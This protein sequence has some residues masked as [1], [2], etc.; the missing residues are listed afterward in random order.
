[1]PA[2]AR[3]H[4]AVGAGRAALFTVAVAFSIG[5][6]GGCGA[7]APR[8]KTPA[9]GGV[10]G[11]SG[12]LELHESGG[13]P[14][15]VIVRREGDPQPAIAIEL[16]IP[17]GTEASG[18][19]T[20]ALTALVAA[21]LE[22][23]GVAGVQPIAGAQYAR[24]RGLVPQ[25]GAQLATA[26]DDALRIPVAPVDP[27][28]PAI[29]HALEKFSGR[30]VDDPGLARAA[31]CLDRPTRPVGFQPL[32][33]AALASTVE[34][35]RQQ[36]VRADAIVL[37]VVGGGAGLDTFLSAWS[38]LGPLVAAPGVVPQPKAAPPTNAFVGLTTQSSE[39]AV[40]VV[41]GAP[42]AAIPSTLAALVEPTSPLMLRLRG[43]DEW[44][45]KG[46]SG[47]ARAEGGCIVVEL[48]PS[49]RARLS[50]KEWNADR[51]TMRAAVALEV[52]RQEI[53]RA[54]DRARAT[55][56]GEAARLAIASGGDAREAADRAAWWGWTSTFAAGTPLRPTFTLTVP[57]PPPA[58]GATAATVDVEGF[59]GALRPKLD[60]ALDRAKLAWARSEIDL[61]SRLEPGQ[62]ELWA[63]LGSSCGVAH[64]TG[65]DAGLGN[66]A[67]AALTSTGGARA[68][69]D[70]VALESWA[71]PAGL[72]IVAHAVARPAE[73]PK[74]LA[75]RVG[76][77]VA[78]AFLATFPG[79]DAVAIARADALVA[80][81]GAK[82]PGELVHA[83][84]RA[85]LPERPSWL[86]ALG[87]VDPVAR[88]GLDSMEL[89]LATLR[90][91]PLRLAVIANADNDQIDVALRA[92]DRWTPRRP[93]ESRACPS[94][95][96]GALPKGGIDPL[97]VKTGTGVA[98][99][100]AVDDAQRDAAELLAR[101]L[102]GPG[103]RLASDVGTAGLGT[104]YEARFVRGIGRSAL[105]V[106]A[107]AP[108]ANLDALVQRM[109]ALFDRLRT[110]G[111]E[112]QDLA[113]AERESAAA[114]TL[115]RLEPRARVVD[116]FLGE[117]APSAS[118]VDLA[119][120][121]A[122]ASKLLDEDRAHLVVA[123]LK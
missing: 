11:E 3:R 30:A 111:L 87:A 71:A 51:V 77:E 50:G 28:I 64:E 13:R 94:I 34:A 24:V 98:F 82:P 65:V 88:T 17:D 56:D 69:S 97:V 45:A 84:L 33:A 114:L 52:T 20:A 81:A 105:V 74:A 10:V 99:A 95:D 78:R 123:H 32:A 86:S 8:G 62:G 110:G 79:S 42:R 104:L 61:R 89:R 27:A 54:I 23:L 92:A 37:G 31:R 115:R 22:R 108:D 122:V 67:M 40:L 1:M 26:I 106:V 103:G 47:A 44:Q 116:L 70:G 101:V 58:K 119:R 25:L 112:A 63:V 90:A 109:R 68:Q 7:G 49:P 113:R 15:I 117:L 36:A 38:A 93:G 18:A 19:R 9:T 120:L 91:S 12:G 35:W 55:A 6:G 57:P 53:E 60:G 5:S 43:A 16:R 59:L 39:G 118:T 80:L 66:L 4:R 121:R 14:R 75:Q 48:E 100:F 85:L 46:V 2:H 73:T 102:D 83:A 76:D 21:R 96:A 29:Q 72:G 107:L 41:E